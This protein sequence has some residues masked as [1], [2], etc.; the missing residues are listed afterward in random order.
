MSRAAVL[1]V[2]TLLAAVLGCAKL[3]APDERSLARGAVY[4]TAEA[5]RAAD[6]AC[7]ELGKA[8][9]DVALLERCEK[10]YDLARV[11]LIST[12]AAVDLW[13]RAGTRE[14]VTCALAD[15]LA[16]VDAIGEDLAKVG[17]KVP[18]IV[19]DAKEL[20]SA[21]GGCNHG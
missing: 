4:A 17:A 21:I 13:D 9:R 6:E 18:P 5:V 3:R 1:V 11:A 20:V 12:A 14:S 2:V 16:Q 10:R 8:R 7:A 15:A 19:Q